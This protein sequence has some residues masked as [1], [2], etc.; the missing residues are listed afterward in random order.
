[1]DLLTIPKPRNE[2][3][4]M[5][6]ADFNGRVFLNFRQFYQG[7]EGDMRPSKIGCTIPV[8][9]LPELRQA[10]YRAEALAQERGLLPV[11]GRS[12]EVVEIGPQ[13]AA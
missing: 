3:L 6:L 7:P 11:S 4:R 10:I 13:G 1:M 9:A 12:A 5:S 8:S 2:E